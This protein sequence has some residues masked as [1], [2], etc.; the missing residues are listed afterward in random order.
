M[1]E[2]RIDS[3]HELVD[4]IQSGFKKIKPPQKLTAA[5]KKFWNDIISARHE[6]TKIDLRLAI[7]L[8][9]AFASID[10][11]E[12]KLSEEDD[13][14]TNARGTQI[15]NPRYNILETLN[16]RAVCLTTKLQIHA[17]A[18]MGISR[19]QVNKNEA[20]RQVEKALEELEDD[21]IAR[22]N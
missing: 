11:Q 3:T 12:K 18:T 19:D 20:K 17:Q 10:E 6:W 7:N 1:S 2:K 16:R 5:Q 13:I 21:L 22:P 4:K 8:A 14:L 9:R 15:A